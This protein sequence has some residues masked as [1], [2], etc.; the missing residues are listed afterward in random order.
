MFTKGYGK[1]PDPRYGGIRWLFSS[2]LAASC[3]AGPVAR[4]DGIGSESVGT[5]GLGWDR[6]DVVR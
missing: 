2:Q 5:E 6:G 1:S 3:A 4:I